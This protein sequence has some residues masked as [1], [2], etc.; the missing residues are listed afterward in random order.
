MV[1]SLD[2]GKLEGL[3]LLYSYPFQKLLAR[4]VELILDKIH[5]VLYAREV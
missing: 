2:S 1:I 5:G 4:L 3:S